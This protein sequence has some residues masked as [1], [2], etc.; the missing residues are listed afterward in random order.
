MVVGLEGEALGAAMAGYGAEAINPYLAF[1]TLIA[2]K[3][4]FPPDLTDDEIVALAEAYRR[5]GANLID[6]GCTV[7][8]DVQAMRPQSI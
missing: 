7:F 4:E 1:E 6:L 3:G 2:M 5:S 8:A